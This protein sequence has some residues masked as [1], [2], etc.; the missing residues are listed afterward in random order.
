MNECSYVYTIPRRK[1][2]VNTQFSVQTKWLSETA[3]NIYRSL[4]NVYNVFYGFMTMYE[5]RSRKKGK[6]PA[7]NRLEM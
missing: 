6:S 2:L 7:A 4:K 5:I 1:G 3:K